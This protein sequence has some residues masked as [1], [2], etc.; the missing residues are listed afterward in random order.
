MAEL[1]ARHIP[2]LS[3][4]LSRGAR[5][6]FVSVTT[7]ALGRGIRLS[8]Q[9]ASKHLVELERD[10]FV[11]R[12]AGGST[13]VRI[14]TEGYSEMER[15]YELL[16]DGLG[17]HPSHVELRGTLV[18]GAGEGTYYMSL[19][20][21]ARQFGERL[22]YV[23]FPGTLNVRLETPRYVQAV[24]RFDS[25]DGVMIDAFSDGRRTYGWVKCFAGVLNGAIPCS[26]IRLERTHHD[27]SIMELIS[28]QNM[29][30]AARLKNGSDVT[31]RIRT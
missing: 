11:E 23:P 6:N 22:G 1:K 30:R 7:S 14:T 2:T 31:V 15:I 13:S 26:L 24:R 12:A 17:T 28:Q 29:R 4:L 27:P 19:D 20:G 8:Q 9:A 16:R 21:Y 18:S 5:H 25:L 10:G 3:Y